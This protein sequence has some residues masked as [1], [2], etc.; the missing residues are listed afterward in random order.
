[1]DQAL[2]AQITTT[3]LYTLTPVCS[4]QSMS[5][6]GSPPKSTGIPLICSFCGCLII[7][8]TIL[9]WRSMNVFV[10]LN[11]N[12]ITFPTIIASMM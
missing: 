2:N 10:L 1:M 5:P 4:S 12:N 8:V 6:W 3:M 7:Y 9:L 11:G